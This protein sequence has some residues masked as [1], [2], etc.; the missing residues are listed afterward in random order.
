MDRQDGTSRCTVHE[1]HLS[2]MNWLFRHRSIFTGLTEK[3]ESY[4]KT[5]DVILLERKG[6]RVKILFVKTHVC[7]EMTYKQTHLQSNRTETPSWFK[8][9]PKCMSLCWLACE[10]RNAC[11]YHARFLIQAHR[12]IR[13]CGYCVHRQ[14]IQAGYPFFLIERRKWIGKELEAYITDTV[15]VRVVIHGVNTQ[16]A[17]NI[18]TFM[19][20]CFACLHQRRW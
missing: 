4:R 9:Y 18:S 14:N 15:G 16:A 8:V 10:E 11:S 20:G 13:D 7:A 17:R 19:A 2:M 5:A 12:Y 3:G 1:C 6:K